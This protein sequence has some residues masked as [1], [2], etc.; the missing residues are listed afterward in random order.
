MKYNKPEY[1]VVV[2]KSEDVLTASTLED[3]SNPWETISGSGTG[4]E[5]GGTTSL[6]NL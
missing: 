2:M 3:A 5:G 1:K 4:G 6:I